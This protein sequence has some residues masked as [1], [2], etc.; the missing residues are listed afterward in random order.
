MARTSS[1]HDTQAMQTTP[2]NVRSYQRARTELW[3]SHITSHNTHTAIYHSGIHGSNSLS[4]GFVDE[5]NA[6]LRPSLPC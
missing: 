5:P 2:G 4:S 6:V 3:T 1:E